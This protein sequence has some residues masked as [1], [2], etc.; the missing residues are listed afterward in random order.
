[1]EENEEVLR[2]T[3]RDIE[4]AN[5]L[6]LN[7]PIC[8]GPVEKHADRPEMAAVYCTSCQTLYHHVCWEQNGGSCAVLGC[9]GD[10]YKRYGVFDLGPA[11]TIDRK[12]ISRA[13]PPRPG[14]SNGQTRR[15]TRQERRLQREGDGRSFWHDLW[16]SLL[17]AIKLWPSDPS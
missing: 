16:R 9:Q 11:L 12:D 13:A 6:S 4:E 15:L 14:F 7:C 2:I 17:Q 3:A 10:S 8:A 5:R 1:M